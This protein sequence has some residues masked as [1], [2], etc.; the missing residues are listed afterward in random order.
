MINRIRDML[1]Q[2][3]YIE[4]EINRL[5]NKFEKK[6]RIEA[7]ERIK[8]EIIE[9]SACLL[10]C[11]ETVKKMI[12]ETYP[13]EDASIEGMISVDIKDLNKRVNKILARVADKLGFN[14]EWFM[15]CLAVYKNQELRIPRFHKE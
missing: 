6:E 14:Y 11:K 2:E 4:E 9:E 12:R 7:K 13:A 10:N 5:L 8:D 3:R 1:E 15:E